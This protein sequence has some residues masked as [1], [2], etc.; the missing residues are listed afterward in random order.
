MFAF[1]TFFNRSIHILERLV[2]FNR[3]FQ[4]SLVS[5]ER[6]YEI[7][8]EE[9]DY[10]P[11]LEKSTSTYI[12][13][14]QFW[15]IAFLDVTFA[16]PNSNPILNQVNFQIKSGEKVALVG[17]N[18]SGKSTILKL[19]TRLIQAEQGEIF[20]DGINVMSLS[21][22]QLSRRIAYVTQQP[23]IF[24]CSIKENLLLGNRKA[25]K[26]ELAEIIHR[27]GLHEYV[28]ELPNG[29]DTPLTLSGTN[30]SGGQ[31]QRLAI[32]RALLKKSEI[33]LLDEPTSNIEEAFAERFI[34]NLLTNHSNQTVLM[35]VHKESLLKHFDRVLYVEPSGVYD[36]ENNLTTKHSIGGQ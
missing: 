29:L 26:D 22:G 18:G 5:M 16:Y 23:F 32:A 24:H 12:A 10:R 11:L 36:L 3:M 15:K 14:R 7:I 1:L 30:L 4:S 2:S 9:N 35:T 21:R 27:V 25:T 13:N 17:A 8:E 31:L 19:L 28:A 34:M 33:L 20:I 6:I